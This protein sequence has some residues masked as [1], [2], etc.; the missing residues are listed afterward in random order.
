MLAVSDSAAQAIEAILEDQHAPDGAGLRIGVVSQ[1][2]DGAQIGVGLVAGPEETDTVVEHQGAHVFVGEE[3][4][5]ILDDKLLDAE[6]DGEQV[7]FTM[8][9]QDT[10]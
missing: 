3:V 8:R 6:R 2:G 7:A 10:A 4:T 5:E 1:N 9:E